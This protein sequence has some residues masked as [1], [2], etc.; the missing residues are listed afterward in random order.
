MTTILIKNEHPKKTPLIVGGVMCPHSVSVSV[1][2]KAFDDFKKTAA[3]KHYAKFL[4]VVKKVEHK[5][6]DKDKDKDKAKDNA[7]KKDK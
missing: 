5:D 2:A 4:K 3:G 1:D 7:N 6:K